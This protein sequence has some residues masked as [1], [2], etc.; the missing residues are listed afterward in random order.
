MNET[1]EYKEHTPLSATQLYTPVTIEGATAIK[2]IP[3]VIITGNLRLSVAESDATFKPVRGSY[4]ISIVGMQEPLH[5]IW[6]AEGR[7]LHREDAFTDIEFD[8]RGVK[9]GETRTYVVTVQVSE[10]DGWRCIVSGVFV[11]IFVI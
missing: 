7:V 8:L 4:E 10:R 6:S 9:A 3:G 1:L 11:Q 2:R 5:V